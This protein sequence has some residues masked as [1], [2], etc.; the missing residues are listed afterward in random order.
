MT[1]DGDAASH[2]SGVSG[3]LVRIS[4]RI[5]VCR[6]DHLSSFAIP[7]S[8]REPEAVALVGWSIVARRDGQSDTLSYLL[9]LRCAGPDFLPDARS[10]VLTTHVRDFRIGIED[11]DESGL[12]PGE[13]AALAHAVL[14]LPAAPADG[15]PDLLRFVAPALDAL[16]LA[17][18]GTAVPLTRAGQGLLLAEGFVPEMLLVRSGDGYVR[19]PVRRATL[20]FGEA[21]TVE[22]AFAPDWSPAL[23]RDAAI[24]VGGGVHRVGCL[25]SG[26]ES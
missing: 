9:V 3:R 10:I 2:H 23:L 6:I 1:T 17:D 21:R 25:R 20:R 19:F 11:G 22:I 16:V 18:A 13:C 24:L 12:S 15:M 7:L 5:V 14:A 8:V 4:D 26:T